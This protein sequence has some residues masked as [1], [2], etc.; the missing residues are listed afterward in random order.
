[1]TLHVSRL[2]FWLPILLGISIGSS[3]GG[4][5]VHGASI[6]II[7]PNVAGSLVGVGI[8]ALLLPIKYHKV[9]LEEGRLRIPGRNCFIKPIEVPLSDIDLEKSRIGRFGEGRIMTSNGEKYVIPSI[10][11]PRKSIRKVFDELK[12]I[13]AEVADVSNG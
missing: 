4:Y 10:Y 2:R 8:V 7:F 11:H 5:L 3:L 13:K 9:V 6:Y 12:K 1:M